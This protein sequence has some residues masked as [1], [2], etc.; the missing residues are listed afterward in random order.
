MGENRLKDNDVSYHFITFF[1]QICYG[2]IAT[3]G[4]AEA[5]NYTSR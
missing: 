1:R 2:F 5:G 3:F 4:D